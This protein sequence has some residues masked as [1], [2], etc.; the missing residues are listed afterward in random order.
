MADNAVAMGQIVGR[1]GGIGR[2]KLSYAFKAGIWLR[3]ECDYHRHKAKSW[4]CWSFRAATE[5]LVLYTT[6]ASATCSGL[7][8]AAIATALEQYIE[9]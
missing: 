7:V 1:K 8:L 2:E 6:K 4:H 9:S 3:F 5:F